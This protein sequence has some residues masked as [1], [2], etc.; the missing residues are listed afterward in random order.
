MKEGRSKER[1][2]REEEEGAE[3]IKWEEWEVKVACID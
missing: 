2:N 3:V 1:Q